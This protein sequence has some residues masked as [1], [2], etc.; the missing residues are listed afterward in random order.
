[1]LYTK[2]PQAIFP[3]RK[4]CASW[5]DF[6]DSFTSQSGFTLMELLI[7]V[8]ILGIMATSAVV[9]F[10]YFGESI[11]SQEVV[12]LIEDTI[13]QSQLAV[14][15]G[16]YEKVSVNFLENYLVVA[17]EPANDTLKLNLNGSCD[18][19]GQSGYWLITTDGGTLNKRDEQERLLNVIALPASGSI[20]VTDFEEA[21]ET[22]WQYQLTS[23][24]DFS[25]IIRFVRFNRGTS[26]AL[27]VSD[28]PYRMDLQAPY[29][30]K[31]MYKNDVPAVGLV[32]LAL[33]KDG[34]DTGHA[35]TLQA[36]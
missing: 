12:G 3:F 34:Q 28:G 9:G 7:T 20:C 35:L 27:D 8:S 26:F 33:Q 15:N 32:S 4:L 21:E 11:K 17:D 36:Q 25:P 6:M 31:K 29:A 10:G 16:D 30:Q 23:N 14:L 13:E 22:Q 19:N 24:S 2:S 18:N 5:F 1:M